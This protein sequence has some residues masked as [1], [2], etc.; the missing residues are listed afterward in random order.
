MTKEPLFPSRIHQVPAYYC[1][2]R[3]SSLV[4][5]LF[6]TSVHG[7]HL[8]QQ[9]PSQ[10]RPPPRPAPGSAAALHRVCCASAS[11]LPSLTKPNSFFQSYW[12]KCHSI[13]DSSPPAFCRRPF[14]SG[15]LPLVPAVFLF[16]RLFRLCDGSEWCL[17]QPAWCQLQPHPR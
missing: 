2:H 5:P 1:I 15:L 6:N 14:A 17:S 8:S 12:P 3:S 10:P 11:N 13:R 7:Q 4:T 16:N 9:H